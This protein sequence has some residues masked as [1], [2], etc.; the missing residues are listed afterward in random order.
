VIWAGTPA[1][2]KVLLAEMC[3][4][5]SDRK[6]RNARDGSSLSNLCGSCGVVL[7]HSLVEI[8]PSGTTG[9]TRPFHSCGHDGLSSLLC[10]LVGWIDVIVLRA[11]PPFTVSEALHGLDGKKTKATNTPNI[12]P[13]W[14]LGHHFSFLQWYRQR[15]DLETHHVPLRVMASRG[16]C[17]Q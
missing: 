13:G 9:N 8:S 12:I 5:K 7:C 16:D 11:Q 2:V 3:T 17:G 4:S 15:V 14:V 6:K 10:R 1:Q